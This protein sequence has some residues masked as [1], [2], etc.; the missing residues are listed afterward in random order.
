MRAAVD[1][2]PAEALADSERVRD[3]G[4]PVGR[5][6]RHHTARLQE[7][8]GGVSGR[9]PADLQDEQ[10]HELHQAAEPLRLSQDHVPRPRLGL[11]LLQPERPRVP[12]REFS[13]R[14]D[15]P[16]VQG[17]PEGRREGPVRA[18][19]GRE[20]RGGESATGGESRVSLETVSGI[21]H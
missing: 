17:V 9:A 13:R 3:R 16:V 11:Q 10:Y 21:F 8:P 7:I 1:A 15:G 19:R 4:D 20:K 18:T 2:I 5:E 6:R 12:A 14:P